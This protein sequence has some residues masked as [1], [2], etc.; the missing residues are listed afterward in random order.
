MSTQCAFFYKSGIQCSKQCFTRDNNM[1]EHCKQH[2]ILYDPTWPEC[3]QCCKSKVAWYNP[4]R[5]LCHNCISA[6]IPP[7]NINDNDFPP[8]SN[9]IVVPNNNWGKPLKNTTILDMLKEMGNGKSKSKLFGP[10]EFTNVMNAL[11]KL[12]LTLDQLT[13]SHLNSAYA[14]TGDTASC[15]LL[16]QHINGFC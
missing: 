3:K 13:I 14:N 7:I 2:Y 6:V 10:T 4:A 12:N 9:V 11:S 1:L 16:W 8:L 15:E 5:N